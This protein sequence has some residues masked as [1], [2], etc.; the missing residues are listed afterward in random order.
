MKAVAVRRAHP[1]GAL[2]LACLALAAASLLLGWTLDYDPWSWMG[3]GRE[4]WRGSWHLVGGSAWKPL[5]GVLTALFALAG[6]A[7]P[8]LWAIVARGGGLLALVMGYRLA[9]REAGPVAGVLA[10]FALCA[11]DRAV[12]LSAL[13]NSEGLLAG[14]VLWAADAHAR[15]LRK[16]ALWL[17]WA[18]ALI[19]PEIWPFWGL[20]ALLLARRDARSRGLVAALVVGIPILWFVPEWIG[21]GNPLA[22]SRLALHSPDARAT[23]DSLV[24]Q[25]W[26]A[27][28]DRAEAML[29][30][31][32][33]VVAALGLVLAVRRRER[34]VVVAS[35]AVLAWVV[36]VAVMAQLGY[37]GIARFLIPAAAAAAV[38]AGVA[39][40]RLVLL[41][42]RRWMQV[43]VALA[44]AGIVG[45]PTGL[46]IAD[47][48]N[49][50]I[51][52]VGDEDRAAHDLGEVIRAAGGEQRLLECGRPSTPA[53]RY[54][55]VRWTLDR[56]PQIEPGPKASLYVVFGTEGTSRRVRHPP[57]MLTRYGGW[58]VYA[59]CGRGLGA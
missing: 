39:L 16:H 35:I 17:G 6:H 55:I 22:G 41:A 15:G 11:I 26:Q 34:R 37:P 56:A 27:V 12:Q 48:M 8:A 53:Y 51:S 10:F 43:V 19:R 45:V 1:V 57:L 9:A 28:L 24:Q 36:L 33:L 46:W 13:A 5:P 4:L 2:V 40:W 44:A 58:L 31:Q 20:Y 30:L 23:Q 25:P 3:W 14:L 49:A 21:S 47:R 59:T 7:G 54:S 18:A 42:P 52:Y 29:P 38:L 50:Q 32:L